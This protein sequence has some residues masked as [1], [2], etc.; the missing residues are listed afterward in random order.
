MRLASDIVRFHLKNV[1]VIGNPRTGAII[2]LT[3][4]GDQLIDLMESHE[5]GP[6]DVAP[7]CESLVSYMAG[8]GFLRGPAKSSAETRVTSAYLHVTARC[9][10]SCL[11]CYTGTER[12]CKHVEPTTS[13]LVRAIDL[14]SELGVQQLI[15]SGGEPFM[16][17]DID[18]LIAHSHKQGIEQQVI[19]SNGSLLDKDV[20]HRIAPQVDVIALSNDRLLDGE[21]SAIGR[22]IDMPTYVQAIECVR[23]A[24][25]RPHALITVHANNYRNIPTYLAR[26][27]ELGV[28]IGFS[29]L[30]CVEGNAKKLELDVGQL[31][32][33]SSILFENGRV[34][35][36]LDLHGAGGSGFT[37]R[38]S[39]H[40]G[41]GR[42]SVSIAHDGGI[43]PCHML[44]V[45]ELRLGNAFTDDAAT[46]YGALTSSLLPEV[47][48]VEGCKTCESRY[49]CGGG[50]RARALH[51]MGSLASRDPYC[52]YYRESI[53]HMIEKL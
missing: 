16:R 3:A 43:Y 24:G 14:L 19:I 50:C 49:L 23:A 22:A 40:C 15:Y 27:K 10:F 7:S 21:T 46:V 26:A 11:G 51:D 30:S 53:D 36:D 8:H 31:R 47:D 2:G 25:I 17:D 6:S 52:E 33:L 42:V 41:A 39:T 45:E 37:P 32:E 4:E 5:V 38:C 1:P 13:Q 28:T 48:A 29:I 9:N 44:H 18:R 20:L 34:I 12:V 35:S